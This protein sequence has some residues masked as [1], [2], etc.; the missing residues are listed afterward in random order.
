MVE[1]V[2]AG[3]KLDSRYRDKE[4]LIARFDQI[5]QQ[6]TDVVQNY[7]ILIPSRVF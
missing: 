3:D 5:V 1:A 6:R 7:T 2:T 4:N